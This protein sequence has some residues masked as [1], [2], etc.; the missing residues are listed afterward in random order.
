MR[1][2][3]RRSRSAV[4]ARSTGPRLQ[5]RLS[6]RRPRGRLDL[7]AP[8]PEPAGRVTALAA[9]AFEGHVECRSTAIGNAALS[10]LEDTRIGIIGLGYV[11]LPLAVEFGKRYPTVGFDIKTGRIAELKSGKDSTLE[12]TSEELS[13]AKHLVFTTDKADLARCNTFIVTVPTPV[14]KNNR[15]LLTPLKAA[16]ETVGSVLK[17]GDVVV[18]ESTV[19]PG[20]T[21]EFCV[22]ILEEHSG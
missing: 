5:S 15:P 13:S 10:S 17:E 8:P 9:R 3:S 19:Y 4:G 6:R 21:E 12:T 7:A 11:G 2:C 20:C 1:R 16:S 18:Y 22:P 14:G